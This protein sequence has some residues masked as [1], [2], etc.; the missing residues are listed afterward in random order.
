MTWYSMNG[1]V[2]MLGSPAEVSL[3]SGHSAAHIPN[4]IPVPLTAATRSPIPRTRAMPM[5]SR[6]AINSQS[7]QAAPAM[8]WKVSSKG[9]TATRLRNPLVGEPPLIQARSAGVAYPN[10][11]VLSANAH[12]NSNPSTTRKTA[13]NLAA[14][15]VIVRS[16]A[17]WV[18]SAGVEPSSRTDS[19]MAMR[20]LLLG[21]SL[22]SS[23]AV[24]PIPAMGRTAPN[25][26]AVGRRSAPSPAQAGTFG[27]KQIGVG[28]PCS[29]VAGTSEE[30]DD[31][32]HR[33]LELP[34]RGRQQGLRRHEPGQ[35]RDH[36]AGGAGRGVRPAR[37]QR[38]RQDDPGQA[39]DRT[40]QAD[41]RPDH[42]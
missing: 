31:G 41:R 22:V 32:C 10:P 16:G 21:C 2:D 8:V 34:G 26:W 25:P 39:G 42:P 24:A 11:K 23:V 6:P 14:P 37:A 36:P 17:G 13:R 12:R 30:V 28:S 15:V 4:I 20:C 40:P 29:D 5:P 33:G 1:L 27:P 3:A 19:R 38:R 35:R 9:P 7:A 18:R